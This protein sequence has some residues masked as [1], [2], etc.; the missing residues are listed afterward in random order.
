MNKKYIMFILSGL[1]LLITVFPFHLIYI[2]SALGSE[3]TD[4]LTIGE[5]RI[6]GNNTADARKDAISDALKKGLEEYLN[7]YL[8]AQGM[9]NN[10]TILIND[11]IPDAAEQIENY[12]ILAEAKNGDNYNI[13]VRVKINEKLME[14]H[15]REMGIVRIEATSIKVLFMVSQENVVGKELLFWW[16]SPVSN[17]ALT[18]SELKL[19]NIFQEQGFEVINRL[20]TPSNENYSED[21]RKL[22]ISNEALMEWGKVFSADIVIKGKCKVEGNNTVVIDLEAIN[23]KDGKLICRGSQSEPMDTAAPG[24]DRFMNALETAIKG[25]AV[26]FGPEMIKSFVKNDGESSNI[27]ITLKDVNN[28]EEFRVF[29]RYLEEEIGGIKSAVQSR[30]KGNSMDLSVEYLGTKDSFINRLKGYK[31]WPF[32][33]DITDGDDNGIIVKIDREMIDSK[34]NWNNTLQ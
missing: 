34:D 31:G 10:F 21:M 28:F 17:P 4:I 19:H 24:E 30:I 2:G 33:V 18:T 27:L 14:Q 5:G 23:I 15:L 1:L 32:R 7:L 11:I 8:G 20:S 26:Q 12:H 16:N 13:L 22:D 25:I 3:K 6:K 9:A 29:K